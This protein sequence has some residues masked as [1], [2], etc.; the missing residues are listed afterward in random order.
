MKTSLF[1]KFFTTSR[2]KTL[3]ILIL[4]SLIFLSLV[5]VDA[6]PVWV[7]TTPSV[8][9]PGPTTIP[10]NHG[11]DRVGTV[12]IIIL[13]Y[14]NPNPQAPATIRNQAINP[15]AP[16][17]VFNAVIPVA[18]GDINKILQVIAGS[19]APGTYHTIS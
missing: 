10:I 18:A 8:G 5:E 6:Q 3:R 12:Y 16:G 11:I 9:A 19:L 1:H 4:I 15:T 17:I 13:N 14:N 2:E 7:P